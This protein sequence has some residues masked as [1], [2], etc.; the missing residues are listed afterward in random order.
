MRNR[1]MLIA[2]L[3][4]GLTLF[5]GCSEDD[6]V[7]KMPK[8]SAA[9]P[10][11]SPTTSPTPQ[12][13]AEEAEALIRQWAELDAEMQNTG[14]TAAYRNIISDECVSCR[15]AVRSIE[16]LYSAGGVIELPGKRVVSVRESPRFKPGQHTYEARTLVDPSRYRTSSYAPWQTFDGGKDIADFTLVRDNGELLIGEIVST[17]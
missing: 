6:P 5:A 14:E 11:P 9:A 13:E 15:R 4:A 16:K 12:S 17:S 1:G 7:P 2:L 10:T 3:L 8:T